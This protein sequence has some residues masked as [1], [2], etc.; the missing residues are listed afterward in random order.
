MRLKNR[1][2]LEVKL[3]AACWCE[4]LC[5]FTLTLSKNTLF[6]QTKFLAATYSGLL[7]WVTRGRAQFRDEK[8]EET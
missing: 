6:S 3:S 4:Y 5:L 2:C 1:K 8:E 7:K